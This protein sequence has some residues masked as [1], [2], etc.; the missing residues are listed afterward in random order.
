MF[1]RVFFSKMNRKVTFLVRP[2]LKG[3]VNNDNIVKDHY[4]HLV[5]PFIMQTKTNLSKCWLNRSSKL[6]ENN[7]EKKNMFHKI[8]RFQMPE[9]GFMLE[10]FPFWVK[11]STSFSKNCIT[12][13]ESFLT[14]MYSNNCPVLLTELVLWYSIFGVYTINK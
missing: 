14:M 11:K 10:V 4:P 13:K 7:E 1:F 3:R 9:K 6:Q 2:F 12:L 5:Y 8:S